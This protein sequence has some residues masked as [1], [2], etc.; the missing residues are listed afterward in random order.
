[1]LGL[2]FFGAIALLLYFTVV[3]T[4]FSLREKPRWQVHFTEAAGL[5]AGD[6]VLVL[7]TRYGRVVA[8]SVDNAT[9]SV[10]RIVATIELEGTLTLHEDFLIRIEESSFLGGRMVTIHPGTPE[11]SSIGSG[12]L[13]T[14][15]VEESPLAELGK[16]VQ[17]NREDVKKIFSGF[18]SMVE[19]TERGE[20]SLGKLIN[21]DDLYNSVKATFDNARDVTQGLKEGKGTLGRLFSDEKLAD[22]VSTTVTTIGDIAKDLRGGKGTLG[23]LLA[24]ETLYN[25]A[26]EIVADLRAGKGTL[27]KLLHDEAMASDAQTTFA[28]FRTI[29]DKI[30]KGEGS[31]GKLVNDS[32]LHDDLSAGVKDLRGIIADA[33]DGKG[34]IGKLLTDDSLYKDLQTTFRTL[35]RTIEDG[36]ES[37]P[38]GT[39]S[40]LLFSSF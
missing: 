3:L 5:K 28:N 6:P 14:G 20:G 38:I 9:T 7:G 26:N 16:L 24:D 34:T 8:V 4:D 19:K 31:L 35:N 2:I 21:N 10:H 30:A 25:N 33:R 11:K 29:S 32:S 18:R 37:A 27:G 1:M 39:F 40:Q 23:K 36:R 13:L 22:N 12:T 15:T 17:N